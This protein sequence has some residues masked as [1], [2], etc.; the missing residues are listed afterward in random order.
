MGT[1]TR[2]LGIPYETQQQSAPDAATLRQTRFA[3]V[4][5]PGNAWD[6]TPMDLQ[7]KMEAGEESK[8]PT[9]RLWRCQSALAIQETL[10]QEKHQTQ[11]QVYHQRQP[12]C[13]TRRMR[14]LELKGPGECHLE[15]KSSL[16]ASHGL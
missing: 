16:G 1:E 10:V 6:T 13:N 11:A 12:G 4:V 8:G 14:S 5:F 3:A 15:G 2:F 9:H 7:R